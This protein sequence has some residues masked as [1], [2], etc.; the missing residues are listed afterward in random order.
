MLAASVLTGCAKIKT[1]GLNDS[2]KKYFE[3]WISV[4]YPDAVKTSLGSYIIKLEDGTG[5]AIS[6][7]A[8][9]RAEFTIRGLD[10][11][12]VSTS[13]PELSKQLGTYDEDSYYGPGIWARVNN[14]LYAGVDEILQGK[15]V[16]VDVKIAVPGWLITNNRYDTA[17]EYLANESGTDAVYEFKVTE[18]FENVTKWEVDSLIRHIK[19]VFPEINPADT[20]SADPNKKYGFYYL[21]RRPSPYPDS[22]FESTASVYINYIGRLLNGKVFDTNIKDTAKLYNIYDPNVTYGP[23]LINWGESYDA[24]TMTSSSS[25]IIDGF[26]FAIYQ[27]KPYEKGTTLFYSAYGYSSSGSG[28]IIPPY[29]PLRFDIELVD[30]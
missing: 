22:T 6:D 19:R 5:E 15:H 29:S 30:E 12:V 26:K 2:N 18:T 13:S 9:I 20:S 28:T 8:Y 1:T 4:F 25:E 24:L 11:G 17:D 10:G 14:G 7:T 3:S 23:T 21:Q 27:M 16:G